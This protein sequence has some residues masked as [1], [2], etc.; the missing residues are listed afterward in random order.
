MGIYN[1]FFSP[2]LVILRFL[3][4]NEVFF[5]GKAYMRI[6]LTK[7]FFYLMG[8]LAVSQLFYYYQ[9]LLLCCYCNFSNIWWYDGTAICLIQEEQLK[10]LEMQC[11]RK[12]EHKSKSCKLLKESVYV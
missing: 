12:P 11:I 9:G 6:L 7:T 5:V 8:F 2:F 3:F 1:N 4:I 10:Q